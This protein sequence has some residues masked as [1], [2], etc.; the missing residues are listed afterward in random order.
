MTL[1]DAFVIAIAS[2]TCGFLAGLKSY[3]PIV[4]AMA[5][6]KSDVDDRVAKDVV[7]RAIELDNDGVFR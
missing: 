5:E 4:K 3:K 6:F 1:A 2:S 7:D